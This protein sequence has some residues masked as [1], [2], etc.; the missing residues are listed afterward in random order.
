MWMSSKKPSVTAKGIVKGPIMPLP[1]SG[2][3]IPPNIAWAGDLTFRTWAWDDGLQ[4]G[5]RDRVWGRCGA[6]VRLTSNAALV[7][8]GDTAQQHLA[9]EGAEYHQPERDCAE[10]RARGHRR[11]EW[12]LVEEQGWETR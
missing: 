9:D 4:V 6:Q 10:V 8:L 5:V 1:L 3:A 11:K 12:W 2:H 7:A